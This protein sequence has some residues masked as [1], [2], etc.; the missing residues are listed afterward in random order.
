[1]VFDELLYLL[2]SPVGKTVRL[3]CKKIIFDVKTCIIF[4]NLV[5]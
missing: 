5:L 2:S 4:V 1:M 3:T